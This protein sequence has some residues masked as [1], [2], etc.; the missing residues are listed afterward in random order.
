MTKPSRRAEVNSFVKGLITE[1]SPLNFPA[2]ASLDEIN[3]ELN[4]DGTRDRR[5]GMDFE[6]DYEKINTD[7][8]ELDYV[9]SGKNT[10]KWIGVAGSLVDDF[11]VVQT[12]NSLKMFDL[13][14][15]SLSGNGYIG[16][17]IIA[18]FP[19]DV[20]YSF[21]AIDG[22]LV[23]ASGNE[24]IAIVTYE[25]GEVA[26]FTVT[27]ERIKVRDLWGIEETDVNYETDIS[28]RG[29][30]TV[31]NL[32][33]VYNLRNQSWGIPRKDK[34]GVLSDAIPLFQ[35]AIGKYPSNS[36]V[37]W[38]GLQFQ[39]VLSGADPYERVFPELYQDSLGVSVGAAKGYFIIDLLRRGQFRTSEYAN[40]AVKYPT[41][42][43]PSIT[44]VTDY[45]PNG[46]TIVTEFAGRVFYAGFGGEVIDG[47]ARSPNLSNYVFFSQIVKSFKDIVK[48]YQEGDP[49]SRETND[50]VET[51]GGFVRI[52]GAKKILAMYPI[53]SDLIVIADNGVWTISG[54]SDYG[55]SATNLKVSNI[56]SFGGISNKTVVNENKRLF[57]WAEDSIYV[58]AKNQVG[59][60]TVENITQSTIQTL[61]DQIPIL[62]KQKAAGCY[63]PFDKK[64]KWIYKTGTMF[65]DSSVT[66]ELVLDLSLSAFSRNLISRQLS[67][68]LEVIG[69]FSGNGFRSG[70]VIQSVYS[71][72]DEVLSSTD[73]VLVTELVRESGTQSIKYLVAI[74]EG[75]SSYFT[76]ASYNNVEFKDWDR[77]DGNGVDAKAYLLTGAITAGDSA[78]D[79]QVPY[80][81][82]HFKRTEDG[83]DESLV[84]TKQSGCLIRS[85][86]NWANTVNS[87][88]WSALVQAY[89]YRK[90]L[91]VEGPDDP[92]DS[93]FEIITSK[94]KLRG[95]GKAFSIYMET[96]PLKDCRVVGWNISINGNAV[97]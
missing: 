63:D 82:M 53:S 23:V 24:E 16:S 30:G 5:L 8:F 94:N 55:F 56:S 72:T 26:P 70:E 28:Y 33:H 43:Y 79:K 66:Y 46:A 44:T 54:G 49:T 73:E 12:N 21:A 96:E 57:Y 86:W 27:Y 51:D 37:V 89:R 34:L 61:Y 18:T 48:C 87:N 59:D 6:T 88:K 20:D 14:K 13:S 71:G 45:S 9:N 95:R 52:S 35:D 69:L 15:E 38:T 2:N 39:P 47:D 60:W 92:Y 75:S 97:A 62:S 31:L 90:A 41:L 50:V 64:I 65:S 74:K 3:F 10:F 76:F 25:E 1:A 32:P 42:F 67:N 81:I 22:K 7:I 4:R 85:Q 58:I 68:N 91:F 77:Y 83:V 93:G 80:L 36:E 19:I 11:L 17:A 84:P 78:V 29:D 40:N